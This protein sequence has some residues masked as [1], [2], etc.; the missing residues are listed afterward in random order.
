MKKLEPLS[1]LV[2]HDVARKFQP[3]ETL[4]GGGA[5]DESFNQLKLWP[6][7]RRR[8]KF[9]PDETPVGGE[10]WQHEAM[11]ARMCVD[12][13]VSL[14]RIRLLAAV[15]GTSLVNLKKQNGPITVVVLSERAASRS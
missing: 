13:Q 7:V 14:L 2:L 12:A 11:R 4:A 3:D 5:L 1:R 9:Q 8:M 15:V 10:V 6:E